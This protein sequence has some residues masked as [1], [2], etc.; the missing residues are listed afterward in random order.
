MKG[1]KDYSK[2]VIYKIRCNDESVLDFY[3]GH[4]TNFRIRK[5]GHKSSVESG[6]QKVYETIRA[7]GGWK[8]WTMIEVEVYPCNSSTEARIRE[9]HWRETLQSKLNVKRA[10]CSDENYNQHYEQ[11]KEEK[12]AYQKHYQQEHADEIKTYQKQYQIENADKIKAQQSQPINCKCGSTFRISDKTRHERTTKHQ[13]WLKTGK[14]KVINTNK[15]DCGG[16]YQRDNKCVHMRTKKHQDWLK[17][18][19]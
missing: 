12:L 9:E 7:N 4:T 18:L 13:E 10:Y 2:T 19:F 5:N 16:S 6:K 14:I 11:H 15:C 1:L 17:T 3:V 8:N